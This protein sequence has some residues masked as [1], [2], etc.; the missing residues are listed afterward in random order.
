MQLI[1]SAGL[2]RLASSKMTTSKPMPLG[3]YWLTASG[4]ARTHGLTTWTAWRARPRSSRTGTCPSFLAAS[5]RM[6]AD[7]A[8]LAARAPGVAGADDVPG[9]QRCQGPVQLLIPVGQRVP[10][11]RPQGSEGRVGTDLVVGPFLEECA[12]DHVG[13]LGGLN[14]FW[15]R[16]SRWP[17]PC[18]KR[19]GMRWPPG[20]PAIRPAR[21]VIEH[22]FEQVVAVGVVVELG[23]QLRA[24][25]PAERRQQ[26]R[27]SLPP[28]VGGLGE[29]VGRHGAFGGGE[30][31][32]GQR[33]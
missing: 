20:R 16:R 11:G 5:W 1:A 10:V 19:P 30:V 23:C 24:D 9:R 25:V 18:R 33:P 13:D 15:R 21:R 28:R 2:I 32:R 14:S 22:G 17:H 7:F 8:G 29:A 27:G 26:G 31:C 6:I 12:L 3:R 4:D